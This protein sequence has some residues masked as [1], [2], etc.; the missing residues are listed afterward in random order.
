MTATWKPPASGGTVTTYAV[1]LE[2]RRSDGTWAV[3]AK[4][5]VPAD[6]RKWTVKAATAGTYRVTVVATGKGGSSDPRASASV[7]VS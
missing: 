1:V 3:I 6:D 7:T 4:A 2:R 5:T